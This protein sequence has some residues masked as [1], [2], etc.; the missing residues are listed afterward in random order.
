M[1]LED[2][3]VPKIGHGTWAWKPYVIAG[4]AVTVLY[5]A[6]SWY[7]HMQVHN[8]EDR[9]HKCFDEIDQTGKGDPSACKQSL[10]LA[11]ILPWT[12]R[13][14]KETAEWMD[15]RADNLGLQLA[16]IRDLDRAARDRIAEKLARTGHIAP[17][18]DAGAFSVV[19][20]HGR[21]LGV[22]EA[23][24]A[25]MAA[26]AALHLGDVAAVSELARFVSRDPDS[27]S[28]QD[29]ARTRVKLACMLGDAATTKQALAELVEQT[30]AE[31]QKHESP[32][33]AQFEA[34]RDALLADLC[35]PQAPAPSGEDA[36]RAQWFQL[37]AGRSIARPARGGYGLES[38]VIWLDSLY[39][40]GDKDPADYKWEV[41]AGELLDRHGYGG[42]TPWS[43]LFDD[44]EPA[45][46]ARDD[47]TAKLVLGFAD[48]AKPDAA[49]T[50]RLQ[51]YV[52]S[53]HA[54]AG[55]ARRADMPH[56][57]ASVAVAVAAAHH[58]DLKQLA[59]MLGRGLVP[60]LHLAG[61]IDGA[62]AELDAASA[63]DHTA[64][65]DVIEQTLLLMSA[66]RLEDAWKAIQPLPVE[67]DDSNHRN[68]AWLRAALALRLHR[69]YG[70]RVPYF[71]QSTISSAVGF[72]YPLA[73]AKPD[74]QVMMR[75]QPDESE[76]RITT[77]YPWFS[78]DGVL[79][80][81][82]FVAGAGAGKGD[83]EVWLD[84]VSTDVGGRNSPLVIAMARAEA[85]RWRGDAAAAKQWDDRVAAL[86]TLSK[87][88]RSAYL[89]SIAPEFT[90]P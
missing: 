89:L 73:I 50:Y 6:L 3:E 56:A 42:I 34:E 31:N 90:E 45:S 78:G 29:F 32:H 21:E 48:A 87:D 51:A 16:T 7:P 26:R 44:H 46:P 23:G 53:L 12:S 72:Y 71:S 41:S 9:A 35:D 83:V 84:A 27:S 52:L 39:A 1:S 82:Y 79:P 47:D 58:K 74:K 68:A 30:E 59:P 81:A 80:A 20:A 54:A 85:A 49:H 64:K 38:E 4:A 10:W 88:D 86:R 28:H 11:R 17:A 37:I 62:L 15:T 25:N 65:I 57:K 55:W 77:R 13:D 2:P 40:S 70:T 18:E 22:K 14:A 24:A 66:N 36:D 76:H 8:G 61:D 5:V 19:V 69:D 63:L 33:L 60:Y 43:I 75:L 67:G